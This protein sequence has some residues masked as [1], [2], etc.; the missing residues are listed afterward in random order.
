MSTSPT[1][2]SIT[3]Q[4][5]DSSGQ[6]IP[7]ATITVLSGTIGGTDAVNTTTQPGTPLA[8]IWADP[9]GNT[10]INQATTPLV[11]DG[12]GNYQC[13]A[14]SG[15]YVV[16]IWGSGINGQFLQNFFVAAP[17][18]A[19]PQPSPTTIGGVYSLAAV[20]NTFVTGV[21]LTGTLTTAIPNLSGLAGQ[22]SVSQINALGTPS[23]STY[24]RGDGSWSTI[25]AGVSSV[26]GRSG[27][28][29]AAD[30]DYSFSQISGTVGASQ[31]PSPT[32]ATRGGVLS[33]TPVTSNWVTYIDTTGVPH[34]AQPS[35]GDISGAVSAAQLPNPTLTTL[36]GV[37][38][39]T[40]PGS[41]FIN[42]ISSSGV[43]SSTQPAF[44]DISGS[45]AASQLPNPSVST[46]GGIQAIVAVTSKWINA[47]STSG[48]PSLTQPAFT[49]ISGQAT[50]SQIYT[51]S[52]T[53][54]A[55][56]YLRGDGTWQTP[57]GAGTVSTTGSPAIHQVAVFTS[58]TA[59]EGIAIGTNN[60][61]LL[62]Q[63]GADPTWAQL[64]VGSIYTTSG[65]PS[66][67]T[68]L[69]G[70]G[71]WATPSGAGTVT[72]VAISTTATWLTVGSSPIT[73]SGTITI[74]PTTGLTAN[75][76]L[77]TP[78]GST[79]AVSLR[80]LVGADLPNPSA[81]TLGGIESYVA[82]SHQ[83]INAISTSGVPASTQPAFTD[84]SGTASSTQIPSLDASKITSGTLALAQGGTNA[85][86]A[87]TGGSHQVLQQSSVGAAITVAQLAFTD[88]S[89]VATA[90]QLPNPSASAL[91]GVQSFSGVSNNWLY[92]I[93]TSGVPL[94][95]QPA[96][97]NIS[98]S[99]STAQVPLATST[100]ALAS[101][102]TTV[103]VSSATAP[104][105]GQVLTATGSTAAT[106]QTPSSSGIQA[107]YK[108]VQHA[109]VGNVTTATT[110]LASPS[111]SSGSL[112]LSSNTLTVGSVLHYKAF[113]SMTV[114]Q[115]TM[116]VSFGAYLNGVNCTSASVSL[117]N[118]PYEW[119][120]EA[121]VFCSA[122]GGS[123]TAAVRCVGNLKVWSGTGAPAQ[124]FN[125]LAS[126][127]S[128][129]ATNASQAMDLKMY[130][131]TSESNNAC[132]CYYATI[133]LE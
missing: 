4:V 86:L 65:S 38:A 26:F 42:Q 116:S 95:S 32:N 40:A 58:A 11:S 67:A 119:E 123:G 85:S 46:L 8:T 3:G 98:G 76:V 1:L 62:A 115:T 57:A 59:I 9:Y 118:A 12:N 6:I 49:D 99:A 48:V 122:T 104:T 90:A 100:N 78:N 5:I 25:A 35:F 101:A 39:Y 20:A 107:L 27:A 64:P 68:Y 74:N 60:Y 128:G 80:S 66:S 52:G 114:Y 41:Q 93:S 124:S 37:Q 45:V 94:Y 44:T 72:S 83:W 71:T 87:A 130:F 30:N 54:S 33:N 81:S 92:G 127:T 108:G 82:Q 110:F 13:W 88:I 103:N 73:G 53:P 22:I 106:W 24:L 7:G 63:T 70:D 47:I 29:V 28:V 14:S 15:Y 55:S 18:G 10:L 112:T 23:M 61:P 131:G 17:S 36:G 120:Y 77:A 51:T 96:F 133:T 117:A 79:G 19:V 50:I 97:S 56:T 132:T 2:A 125:S 91:G 21:D 69:R 16:Q 111:Y 121:Y 129:I 113:G 105:A 34:I 109:A 75:Q 89:G 84:I 31:L 43:V 126:V 102:T